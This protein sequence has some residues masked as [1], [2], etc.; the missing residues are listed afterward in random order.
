MQWQIMS[1]LFQQL[2]L[3]DGKIYAINNSAMCVF[4]FTENFEVLHKTFFLKKPTQQRTFGVEE[5][6][7]SPVVMICFFFSSMRRK[8]ALPVS[9]RIVYWMR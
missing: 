5:K 8:T 3:N 7:L 9:F 6:Y 1:K 2:Q 4:C